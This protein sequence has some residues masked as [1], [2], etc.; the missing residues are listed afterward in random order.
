MEPLAVHWATASVQCLTA[1]V[2]MAAVHHEV[3]RRPVRTTVPI[4][5]TAMGV[6]IRGHPN[7]GRRLQMSNPPAER[8]L[9][10][11][12]WRTSSTAKGTR[13][14]QQ[15]HSVEHFYLLQPAFSTLTISQPPR[16]ASAAAKQ[17]DRSVA[18]QTRMHAA[19][20]K[21]RIPA[22]KA[23]CTQRRLQ[24]PGLHTLVERLLSYTAATMTQ[25]AGRHIQTDSVLPND[26]K[27]PVNCAGFT[28]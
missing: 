25:K 24:T 19:R 4:L 27:V 17:S 5:Q 12:T 20:E 26:T 14:G 1:L 18:W 21:R 8:Q 23:A 15:C 28:L 6:Q 2:C 9:A 22:H 10:A 16:T 11:T 3:A 13:V 7:G